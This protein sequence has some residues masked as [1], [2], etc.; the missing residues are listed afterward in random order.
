M[1]ARAK[2]EDHAEQIVSIAA[3]G[4][5]V[6]AEVLHKSMGEADFSP[7]DGTIAGGFDKSEVV[8]VLGIANDPVHSLL[9]T[10]KIL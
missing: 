7:V 9:L 4:D 8:G 3:I 6:R 10:V 1:R 5:R 2:E